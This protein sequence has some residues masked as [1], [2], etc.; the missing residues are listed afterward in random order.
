MLHVTRHTSHV[1][2]HTSHVTRHT[3]HVTRHTSHITRH[4]SAYVC[5]H[6]VDFL[7]FEATATSLYVGWGGSPIV[8]AMGRIDSLGG[9]DS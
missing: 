5:L 3:S 9:G 7:P 2:R 8:H 6:D 4:S 1:T